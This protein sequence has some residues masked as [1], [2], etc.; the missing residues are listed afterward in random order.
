MH[1][2][3][4]NKCRA[5]LRIYWYVNSSCIFIYTYNCAIKTLEFFFASRTLKNQN[6]FLCFFFF[7]QKKRRNVYKVFDLSL[8]LSLFLPP[9]QTVL[10]RG[11]TWWRAG[12]QRVLMLSLDDLWNKICW[13]SWKVSELHVQCVV[14]E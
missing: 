8:S 1:V 7:K 2:F 13:N 14:R 5:F 12:F 3:I 11:A 4:Y 10:G 6:F 9:K